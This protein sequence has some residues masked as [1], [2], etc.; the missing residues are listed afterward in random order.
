M[1]INPS[2]EKKI[3]P[4]PNPMPLWLW[5]LIIVGVFAFLW[6]G[7]NRIAISIADKREITFSKDITNRDISLFLWQNPKYMR[8]FAIKKSGYLPGFQSKGRVTPNLATVDDVAKGTQELIYLYTTWK[9]LIGD[10]QNMRKIAVSE[11]QEFLSYAQEWYPQNWKKAP[12][13]Y[14]YLIEELDTLDIEDMQSL[15]LSTFPKGARN[16]FFGWKNFFKEKE[17]I[18]QQI[19]TF[20]D[21]LNFLEKYPNY[22]RNH[23]R[24]IYPKYLEGF[25]EKSVD[26]QKQIPEDQMQDFLKIGFFNLENAD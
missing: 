5:I 26:L 23:W 12:E 14:R 24:N 15:P 16:A 10:Y 21:M 7:L 18:D 22:S 1:V 17:Q 13:D 6:T 20:S 9:I 25:L 11:Y 4:L 2:E 19:I 3:R 8:I